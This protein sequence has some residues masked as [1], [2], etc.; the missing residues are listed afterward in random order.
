[1]K[2]ENDQVSYHEQ[3][4]NVPQWLIFWRRRMGEIIED[5]Q[6]RN[7]RT[8]RAIRQLI[9]VRW[10]PPE[11][12]RNLMCHTTQLSLVFL[13]RSGCTHK[14]PG[15]SCKAH[16]GSIVRSVQSS[17]QTRVMLCKA[18]LK[19]LQPKVLRLS[20]HK[21]PRLRSNDAGFNLLI[22]HSYDI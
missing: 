20:C 1:M 19:T 15:D 14:Y 17:K 21:Y 22:S 11:T 8:T 9:N 12:V 4:R 6:L 16:P 5:E 13:H 18:S 2:N 10:K 7:Q 3:Y